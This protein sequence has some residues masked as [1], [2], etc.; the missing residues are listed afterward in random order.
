MNLATTFS[1]LV[2]LVLAASAVHA[3]VLFSD[4]FSGTGADLHGSAPDLRPGSETWVASSVFNADGSI[5]QG[6]GSATVAFVPSDGK[7]YQLDASFAGVN[8]DGDWLAVG[9]AKGQ[10]TVV[11]SNNRFISGNTVGK[12][13]MLV[14]GDASSSMN[15]A[16]MNG[17]A[18]N[19]AWVSLTHENP[20]G[21]MDMRIVLDTT[22]GAG[23]WSATWFAKRPA[24]ASYI[25]MR[26]ATT[27]LAE[28][29][30]SVGLALSNAGV[31]GTV[32][33][34]S[35]EVI[36]PADDDN[37]GLSDDWE[38]LHFRASPEESDATILAKYD[39]GDDPDGD[40]FDNE[41][42]ETAGTDPND[43]GHTPLDADQDGYQDAWEIATFGT[44]SYG[45]S[46]DPDG[47]GWTSA[48]ELT[49]G[50]DPA[51]PLSNPDDIDADGLDDAT[52]IALFG[53]LNQGPLDDFDGDGFANKGELQVGT[54]PSDAND[55]PL[56]SFIPVSDGDPTTDENGYA[57]SGINS[58]AFAQNNLITVGDQQFIAYYRRH[59]SDLSHPDN[60]TVVIGRRNLG[61]TRW[62][63][64]LATSIPS[65]STTIT[66]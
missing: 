41:A 54:D 15:T 36:E 29:I 52:E 14:K 5:D 34:F 24:D 64:S 66:M 45:P 57:G 11:G 16:L 56:V 13:W 31:F 6:A 37:D 42:E 9:F 1:S 48:E 7:V 22:S 10:S 23:G 17:T 20:G 39:A 12:A 26:P 63:C 53:D 61:E 62:R 33:S 51:N 58:V 35:L 28:D 4:D 27:L 44:I 47:D 65:T 32:E 46:D 60:N 49:A 8:G 38:I 3:G 21:D 19:A 18:S 55:F 25:E 50:T 59:A 43:A 30:D 2:G 40:S